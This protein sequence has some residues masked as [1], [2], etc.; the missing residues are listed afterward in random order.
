[1]KTASLHIRLFHRMP[2]LGAAALAAVMMSSC[3]S[4]PNART[5]TVVG[6]LG[7]AAVGG[8]IGHQSGR[9]LEGAAIGGALGALGGNMIGDS[10]DQRNYDRRRYYANRGYYSDGG[11]YGNRGYYY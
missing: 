9:G 4:G 8:I 11:Y 1:M 7:G 3:A 10:Q 2:V 5:G 6:G